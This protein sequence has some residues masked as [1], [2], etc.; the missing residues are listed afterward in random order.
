[1]PP[2]EI[3]TREELETILRG[4][5]QANVLSAGVELGV[6]DA[7]AKKPLAAADVA[8]KIKSNVRGTEILL[9]AL[10]GVGLLKKRGG[11]FSLTAVAKKHL[12]P[13]APESLVFSIR[14][15]ANVQRSWIDLPFAVKT[16]RPVP[17]RPGKD[18]GPDELKHR[19]FI[20]AMHDHSHGPAEALADA[21]DLS[22]VRQVLDVGGGPGS[23]L[24]AMVR[25]NP[26]IQ[27]AVFDLPPTIKIT[28]D[29]I[30][31]NDMKSSVGTI[32]GD[33]LSD[34]FGSGYD[35]ILMSSI[36]HINSFAENKKL[37]RKA[38]KALNPGGVLVIRDHMLDDSK[39]KPADGALFSVNMLV[40]TVKGSSFSKSE[41]RAWFSDAGFTGMKYFELPQRSPIMIGK[42]P[43]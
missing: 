39:T 7:L 21:L 30:A 38:F 9:N 31:V 10:A 43:N 29:L 2:S 32:E 41:I 14:H 33:F 23:F 25:K 17:R 22:R 27:G 34:D 24:F 6:F 8:R 1:M 28:R 40:N 35:L 16:G 19:D 42:K 11:L 18:G 15:S 36:V 13:G 26:K 3:K 4:Y 37:V 12:T 5:R 20:L